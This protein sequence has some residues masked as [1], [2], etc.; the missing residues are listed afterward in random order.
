MALTLRTSK[1]FIYLFLITCSTQIY[2]ASRGLDLTDQGYFLGNL[3]AWKEPYFMPISGAA[4]YY[5]ISDFFLGNW[6]YFASK[7]FA[8]VQCLIVLFFIYNFHKKES[9]NP[10]IL[11]CLLLLGIPWVTRSALGDWTYYSTLSGLTISLSILFLARSLSEYKHKFLLFNLAIFLILASISIK[12]TNVVFLGV[13]PFYLLF[14]RY[15]VSKIK[16]A[17]ILSSLLS[18][19]TILSTLVYLI[20]SD[21]QLRT[22]FLD[23]IQI[24]KEFTSSTSLHSPDEL[25]RK[26]LSDLKE[27]IVSSLVVCA[28]IFTFYVIAHLKS[29]LRLL[30]ELAF[31]VLVVFLQVNFNIIG[32]VGP[33]A[34]YVVFLIYI[35]FQFKKDDLRFLALGTLFFL[36]F[37]SFGSGNGLKAAFIAEPMAFFVIVLF[38][39]QRLT[40][41]LFFTKI[42]VGLCILGLLTKIHAPYRDLQRLG[43]NTPV[44][45]TPLLR[46]LYTSEAR[47]RQITWLVQKRQSLFPDANVAIIFPSAPLLHYALELKPYLANPWINLYHPEILTRLL[48]DKATQV[49]PDVIIMLKQNPRKKGWPLDKSPMEKDQ[50][51]SSIQI[52]KNFISSHYFSNVEE[53]E[54]FIIYKKL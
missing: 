42:V 3:E 14:N 48:N 47:N 30:T 50:N 33:Y 26:N 36:L 9:Q 43:L 28:L 51:F 24:L 23:G 25:L 15:S 18:Y 11:G 34:F 35:T 38:L 12:I 16:K 17:S 8:Q 27:S 52:L 21:P 41:F 53:N 4:F 40:D 29:K 46:G 37:N 49:L 22:Y 2:F 1:F 10:T 45:S 39:T 7:L 5:L 31:F 19:L 13:I 6:T 54:H 20:Y 32:D 44:S